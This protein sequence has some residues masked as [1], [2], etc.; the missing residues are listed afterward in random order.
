MPV[1]TPSKNWGN[2]SRSASK[3][4]VTQGRSSLVRISFRHILTDAKLIVRDRL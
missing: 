2:L 4:R 3:W 1:G